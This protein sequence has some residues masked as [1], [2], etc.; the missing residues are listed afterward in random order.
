[1]PVETSIGALVDNRAFTNTLSS[2]NPTDTF[3]FS[4]SSTQNVLLNANANFQLFRASSINGSLETTEAI[5][6]SAITSGSNQAISQALTPGNYI[7]NVAQTP[8][9]TTNYTLRLATNNP[10]Q[11]YDVNALYGPQTF[12]GTVGTNNAIDLY[13]FRLD[14]R[15]DLQIRLRGLSADADL[16][17][18]ADRNRN[19][20]F[21][22]GEE[23][24]RS[25]RYRNFDELIN[26]TG[27]NALAAGEYL[28]QVKQFSG[29]T[30]Y[31][32]DL[33]PKAIAVA[34]NPTT[35]RPNA[36]LTGEILSVN[37]P[38]IRRVN[39]AG[40]AQLRVMNQGQ[41]LASGPIRVNLYASTNQDIDSNDQ[42]IDS[43]VINVNLN[44]N[45]SQL[46]NFQFG[47]PTGVAP[48]FYYLV[49]RI[50]S[51]NA[52]AETNEQFNN[53]TR[54]A[55]S[56]PGTDVIL[57]WNAMLLNAIQAVE[58]S[59]PIAARNQAI[60]HAAMFDAVNGIERRYSNFLVN[61]RA[62]DAVN[63]STTAAAAQ[64][65]Y[66][67]LVDLYPTQRAEFQMQL[68]R[69]LAEVPDGI[70]EDN[71]ITVGQFVADR[72]LAN[73]VN[74][75]VA[76][77]QDRY[78]PGTA[79]GSYQFTRPDNFVAL[80]GFGNVTPFAID[81]VNRFV[82]NNLPAYGSNLYAAELNE[83][84]RLGGVN[85][86]ARTGDQAEV[87]VFWAY[88]RGDT[89]RPPAQWN[90]IAQT[91][92]L[93]EG[94][95]L[96]SNA[97][98]FAHLN[99]AQADAGIVAW[100]T[101][102]TY[103]QLRPI[104]AVRLA[105]TDGNLQTIVDPNWQSYLPTPPFPDY[106]SGHATFGA[107]AAQVLAAYYGDNYALNVSSQEIHGSYRSFRSFQDAAAENGISR[108]YGGVHIQ[109]ANRDGLIAGT[110]VANY[111]LAN[112]LTV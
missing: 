25:N 23:I 47:A 93:Q 45:Q 16:V 109:S 112:T 78:T 64:A 7:I 21:D 105:D 37:A 86:N 60:V 92:A 74:D 82:P 103:N 49:A 65:A 50:D 42:I 30:H 24:T 28:V 63:A 73:R 40:Q 19:G 89:F 10:T 80:S 35:G 98:L 100:Q 43:Q 32:L 3:S 97:R 71:G 4:L 53:D 12:S 20:V 17:L 44:Q 57:D 84:Q 36:D 38:D 77:S 52:I 110:R 61:V 2:L 1:M 26:R 14:T 11:T 46:V 108:I 95:S 22:D 15:S 107:A 111:V 106:I 8:G 18:G 104:T 13:R 55:V 72:I 54:Y 58:T 96:L 34:T 62:E 59:P 75:G 102:Y 81:N 91:V 85:S 66:Q 67:V 76:G 27:S 9:T 48:G 6:R 41:G 69:S 31:R 5:A 90:Q 56:A 70:T 39:S 68:E 87:A 79:P 99:I 33:T 83:V 88:D 51:T 29:D 101:K 94:S